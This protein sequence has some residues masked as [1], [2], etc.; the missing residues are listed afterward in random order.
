MKFKCI[1]FSASKELRFG[2]FCTIKR[3][4]LLTGEVFPPITYKRLLYGNSSVKHCCDIK[5]VVFAHQLSRNF[6]TKL[7]KL[8]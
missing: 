7:R 8:F 3:Q 5:L 2:N 6:L 1:D 4:C